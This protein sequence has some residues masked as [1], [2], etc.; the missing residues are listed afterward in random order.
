LGLKVRFSPAVLD[1]RE[2]QW[3]REVFSRALRAQ[4]KAAQE[5]VSL[6]PAPDT[7]PPG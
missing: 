7:E 4:T 5:Q 3:R 1:Y 6:L 2:R